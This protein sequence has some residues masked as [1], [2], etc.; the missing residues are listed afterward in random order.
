MPIARKARTRAGEPAVEKKPPPDEPD[1]EVG[2]GELVEV[3][4]K[5]ELRGV[6]EKCRLSDIGPA[7]ALPRTRGDWGFYAGMLQP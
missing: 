2:L 1:V 6:S 7:M 5:I 3:G 4:T